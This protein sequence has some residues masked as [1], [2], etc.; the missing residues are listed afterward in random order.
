MFK[1][2]FIYFLLIHMIGDYYLQTNTLAEEKIRSKGK[3]YQ[4]GLIY[5][6]ASC[7]CILP[8][9]SPKLLLAAVLFSISHF[10]IDFIKFTY[11]K[12]YLR[13]EYPA[14]KE[15]LLYLWDQFFHIACIFVVAYIWA[16][17]NFEFAVMPGMENVFD[18]IGMPFESF[19]LWVTAFLFIWKPA[20]I[21]IKQLLCVHRPCDEE[22]K[23]ANKQTGGFIGL[24][25]RLIILIL[26]SI[27][28]YSAIGLV[29]T[30]KSIARY[31]RIAEDQEFAEYYLLGTLL[32]TVIV[33]GGY[34]V[35]I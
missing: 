21:T 1:I 19:L 27:N 34:L 4:H 29:L 15:R 32:S 8:I 16:D 23:T 33:I 30:A 14:E 5:L 35:I 6:L 18:T 28:Q 26:L 17:Q 13:Y 11:I 10:I 2:V 3:L 31:N 9:Y 25:E 7:I 12:R 20:N 22:D 24:L